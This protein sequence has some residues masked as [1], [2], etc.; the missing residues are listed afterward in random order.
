[1]FE[2]LFSKGGLSLE[3]LRSFLEMATAGSIAKAAPQDLTRQSLISRQIKELEEYF[4][5]ELTLRRGKTLSLSPAGERLATLVREQ[6]QDLDD[7]RREQDLQPKVFTIGAGVSTLE[8]LLSPQLPAIATILGG[9]L[10]RTEP[11]RSQH[12]VEGIQDGRIDLAIVR[13]DVIPDASRHNCQQIVKLTFHLCIPK[14]LL[15][16]GTTGEQLSD[17]SIWQHLPFAAGRDTGTMDM[18]VRQGMTKLGVDFKPQFECESIL[19][20]RQLVRQGH[21]AAVLPNLAT[22]GLEDAS[23][24][25]IPF[26]PLT[27][28]GRQLV[29]HWNPR[30]MQRRG[31]EPTQLRAIAATMA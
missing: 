25:T 9:A 5:T 12:L 21:C 2:S 3:R 26:A 7:F 29:L 18:A 23:I 6:L 13:K 11:R 27:N 19:Q 14:R 8:W 16:R 4:G 22:V 20:I 17:V 30:Q 31:I 24:L 1:M 10:L 28:Y 15:K